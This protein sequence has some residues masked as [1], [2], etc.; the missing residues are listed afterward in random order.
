MG[1]PPRPL[2]SPLYSG[3][4]LRRE[5]M[6]E[7]G[8]GNGGQGGHQGALRWTANMSCF[9]LRHMVELIAKGARTDKGFKEAHLNQVTR[10]LFDHYGLDI[11]GTQVYNHLCKWHQRWVCITRLKDISA[12]LWDDHTSMIVLEEE[13]YMGYVK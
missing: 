4:A 13:H 2:S 5:R 3:G 1:S 10:V 9:M 12:A 8:G 6:A 7:A 11:S